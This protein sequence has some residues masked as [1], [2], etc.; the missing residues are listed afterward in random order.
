M[1][2]PIRNQKTNPDFPS[3]EG[4]YAIIVDTIISEACKFCLTI[5]GM[6]SIDLTIRFRRELSVD[7]RQSPPNVDTFKV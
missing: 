5:C 6:I 1:F 3:S 2:E 7:S 4:F